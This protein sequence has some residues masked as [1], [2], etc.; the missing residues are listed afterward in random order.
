VHHGVKIL[1]PKQHV[2]VLVTDVDNTL[3]DCGGA[4]G[5]DKSIVRDMAGR[6]LECGGCQVAR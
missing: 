3:F 4:V 2:S 1:K 5:D 6:I